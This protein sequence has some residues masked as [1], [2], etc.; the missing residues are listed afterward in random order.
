MTHF[1][2]YV[3][4]VILFVTP[5]GGGS[6]TFVVDVRDLLMEIP[7]FDNAPDFNLQNSLTGG[8]PIGYSAAYGR[9]L[10]RA[11][12][13]AAVIDLMWSIHPNAQS[14]TIWQGKL[15]IRLPNE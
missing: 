11:E 14:I 15:F 8:S 3:F 13:E 2:P 9:R 7:Q 5:V 1:I 12:R 4:A 6:Q 10:T